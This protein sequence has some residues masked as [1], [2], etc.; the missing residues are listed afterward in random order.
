MVFSKCYSFRGARWEERDVFPFNELILSW[1]GTR[2]RGRWTFWVS[3]KE[4]EWLKYAEWGE[5]GQRSFKSEGTFAESFQDVVT[6]KELCREFRVKVEGDELEKLDALHVC[7]SNL[8]QYKAERPEKLETVILEGMP[9]QSQMT[10][11]HPRNRDLCSPTS[12]ST[13]LR[14]LCKKRFDPIAF[15]ARA[16]DEGFDIYG[17]WVLNVAEAYNQSQV[18]C[19]VERL[20]D[21]GALHGH[22]IKGKPVVVSVKG[23]IPGAPSAYNFGHL[24][25]V[26]GFDGKKVYCIDSRFETDESTF[27]GYALA[28]FLKAWGIRRNLAYIFL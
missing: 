28:D 23:P 2:P 8:A 13:A 18:P 17:N 1:N 14:F 22:L 10:I 24:M 16:R 5:G 7:V 4:G 12:T 21:F 3:L 25:C 15:A 26:I 9:R 20:G 11:D 19:R 6:A 27:F